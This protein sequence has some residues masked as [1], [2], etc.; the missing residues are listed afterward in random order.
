MQTNQKEKMDLLRKEILC[1]QGLD[2]KPGHEQ[3]HVAL[4]S[5]LE[6]M[7]GQAF[8][9]GAI[10]EFISATPAASA[11]TTGFIAALLNTLMKSNPCCIW[12][13]LHRKVFP[14]ALKVFGIDPDRVIFIDAG[15]EKEAL[16]VIEEALKCKAI[17]AVVGEIKELDFTQ[18]RR[19]QLAVE[20]SR[21][22]GFIHIHRLYPRSIH[23]NACVARWQIEPL[24]SL[25]KDGLPGTGF[26]RWQVELLKI[27]SGLPGCWQLEWSGNTFHVTGNAVQ[28]TAL[29]VLQTGAA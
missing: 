1:L 13:N 16:W 9:T 26:P 8:P 17:G 15:S 14:P 5:I 6:N 2:A 25:T 27:R 4:G 12:V 28:K 11:A 29:P 20:N 18:S 7:P 10:H 3:P 22:T 19:L 24:N 23:P 21:V